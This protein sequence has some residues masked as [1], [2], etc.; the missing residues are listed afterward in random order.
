MPDHPPPHGG[1]DHDHDHDHAHGHGN[2]HG[3]V[4]ADD[5]PPPPPKRKASALTILL[6]ILLL[7]LIGGLIWMW[8]DSEGQKRALREQ[9]ASATAA[10]SAPAVLETP[11]ASETPEE[12]AEEVAETPPAPP[13]AATARKKP[14]AVRPAPAPAASTPPAPPPV[15]HEPRLDGGGAPPILASPIPAPA[16]EL[17]RRSR[18]DTGFTTVRSERYAVCVKW[19][20]GDPTGVAA[21]EWLAR[22]P[23][24]SLE[25]DG[26]ADVAGGRVVWHALAS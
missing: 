17:A 3:P 6:A 15:H 10:A 22:Q 1:H 23:P 26:S 4:H 12:A 21:A 18:C 11:P 25:R 14:P 2:A 8:L 7:L 13:P 24:V 9:L 5:P 16:P 20:G 19:P